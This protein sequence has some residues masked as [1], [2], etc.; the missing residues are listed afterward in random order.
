MNLLDITLRSVMRQKGKK[1]FILIAMVLSITT[2]FT[3][4]TFTKS[5]TNKIEKQ[6]D[7]YGANIIITPKTDS[8]SLSYAGIS[9]SEVVSV[10]E[11]N[12]DELQKISG[13]KDFVNIRAISP[14]LIGAVTVKT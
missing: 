8:L 11:I 7:E 3:L 5:Q 2:V 14:K 6:F 13:I 4:Y 12:K 10:N 9:F 1:S